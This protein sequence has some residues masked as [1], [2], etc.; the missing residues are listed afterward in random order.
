VV[1]VVVVVFVV[2]VVVGEVDVVF[3]VEFFSF[4]VFVVV[5]LVVVV[6]VVVSRGKTTSFI[7]WTKTENKVRILGSP[8]LES[9]LQSILSES[10]HGG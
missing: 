3:V 8:R 6:V 10:R 1:V 4:V 7:W 5:V 9:G 2:V